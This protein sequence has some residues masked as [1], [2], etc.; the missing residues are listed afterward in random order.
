MH[1]TRIPPR[2]LKARAKEI[3]DH[4]R[5]QRAMHVV[6]QRQTATPE[7]R[8]DE[9]IVVSALEGWRKWKETTA[10][11]RMVAGII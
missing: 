4:L 6:E 11:P 7:F 10:P 3:R 9:P 1:F 2:R 5:E 8:G